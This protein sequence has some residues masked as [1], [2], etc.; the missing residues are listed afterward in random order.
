MAFPQ[1]VPFQKTFI[2]TKKPFPE[3]FLYKETLLAVERVANAVGSEATNE[4]ELV[5]VKQP[6]I[7]MFDVSL[8]D[9][10]ELSKIRSPVIKIQRS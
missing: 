9:R 3:A 2:G 10:F 7:E 1:F 8:M 6:L 5:V 4:E